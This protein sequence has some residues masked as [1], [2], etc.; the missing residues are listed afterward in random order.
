MRIFSKSAYLRTAALLLILLYCPTM[1][2]SEFQ[3]QQKTTPEEP[4]KLRE[5]VIKMC[6][7]F[8]GRVY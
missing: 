8:A 2:R 4:I 6:S 5:L 1:V 3:C 7:T